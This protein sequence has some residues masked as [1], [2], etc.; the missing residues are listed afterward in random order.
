MRNDKN[1]APEASFLF[2]SC[3][4]SGTAE[5]GFLVTKA[6]NPDQ[7][8][9]FFIQLQGAHR[10]FLPPVSCICLKYQFKITNQ[11]LIFFRIV[12]PGTMRIA[13]D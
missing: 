5:L 13:E 8:L 12:F 2:I 4:N 3:G 9:A 1:G 10:F 11:I 7:L 6:D